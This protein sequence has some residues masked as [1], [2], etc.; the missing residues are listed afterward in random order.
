[1]LYR[2][3][4]ARSANLRPLGEETDSEDAHRQD[5]GVRRRPIVRGQ[6]LPSDAQRGSLNLRRVIL[7]WASIE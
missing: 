2:E 7:Q 1:M 6:Q 4:M 3:Y 5:R